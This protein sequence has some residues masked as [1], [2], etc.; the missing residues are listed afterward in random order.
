M[1]RSKEAIQPETVTSIEFGDPNSENITFKA[2]H[3]FSAIVSRF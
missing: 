2:S 3:K 1:K